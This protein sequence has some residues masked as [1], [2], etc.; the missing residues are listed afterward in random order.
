[1]SPFDRRRPAGQQ[2]TRATGLAQATPGQQPGETPDSG[3]LQP[4]DLGQDEPLRGL[5]WPFSFYGGRVQTSAGEEHLLDNIR[6]LLS[7]AT[8]EC[9]MRP[10]FGCALRDRIFD[11]TNITHL[12]ARDIEAA[13]T[14]WEPRVRLVKAET[15][16][17]SA[18]L[19]KLA[20][21]ITVAVKGIDEVLET[22]V[23][24]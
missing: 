4:G 18:A 23:A 1:M 21:R 7:T 5:H 9:L 19:G 17:S 24:F 12:L 3:I 16:K 6:N 11:P 20:I 13:I 2:D 8:R 10:E 14:R 15:D 22:E